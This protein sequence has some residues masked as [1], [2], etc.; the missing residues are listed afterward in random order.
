R[1]WFD[2]LHLVAL[3]PFA[4]YHPESTPNAFVNRVAEWQA[5]AD[6][7]KLAEVVFAAKGQA[8]DTEGSLSAIAAGV[9]EADALLPRG[10]AVAGD[11]LGAD[12][13]LGPRTFW[14]MLA[15]AALAKE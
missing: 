14:T 2:A 7:A 10:K 9:A 3:N 6:R 5:A 1:I 11:P 15:V 8:G 12:G 13:V 4:P